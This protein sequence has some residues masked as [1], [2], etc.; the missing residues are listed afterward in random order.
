MDNPDVSLLPRKTTFDRVRLPVGLVA[1][2]LVSFGAYYY[3][4][5]A[6]KSEYYSSRNARVVTGLAERLC[7]SVDAVVGLVNQAAWVGNK[8]RNPLFKYNAAEI[9]QTRVPSN[10]LFNA[11]TCGDDDDS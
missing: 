8:E 3:V 6:K 2:S 9:D 1:L 10:L 5:W 4:F 11:I 7:R